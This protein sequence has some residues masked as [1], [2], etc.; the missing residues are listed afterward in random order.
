MSELQA[1]WP[2]PRHPEIGCPVA[3]YVSEM[4]HLGH[5]VTSRS[6]DGKHDSLQRTVNKRLAGAECR[7]GDGLPYSANVF[8]VA[9]AK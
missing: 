6:E 3:L 9:S 8:L 1:I 5:N 4:M 7:L 2:M